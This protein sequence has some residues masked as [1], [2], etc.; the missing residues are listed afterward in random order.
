MN[1]G[2]YEELQRAY[3]YLLLQLARKGLSA[4]SPEVKETPIL[5]AGK[6]KEGFIAVLLSVDSEEAVTRIEP[7]ELPEIEYLTLP[8]YCIPVRQEGGV[9]KVYLPKELNEFFTQGTEYDVSLVQ[10][11]RA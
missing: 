10:I 2:N 5:I 8:R 11:P 7:P 9:L 6:G 4:I 3:N 1:S